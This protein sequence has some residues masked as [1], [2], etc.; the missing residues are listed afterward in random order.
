VLDT[1]PVVEAGEEADVDEAAEREAVV[2]RSGVLRVSDPSSV[3][4][5]L[6]ARGSL[7]LRSGPIRCGGVCV[8][9]C[10]VVSCSVLGVGDGSN[11]PGRHP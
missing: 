4:V 5:T 2:W 10:Q 7:E 6:T 8:E 3:T 9:E 1:S 11:A